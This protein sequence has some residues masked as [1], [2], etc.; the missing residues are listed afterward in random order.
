MKRF[1]KFNETVYTQY[2][3]IKKSYEESGGDYHGD[4]DEEKAADDDPETLEEKKADVE[5]A[6]DQ[7]F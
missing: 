1:T 7:F 2:E 6:C 5:L 3:E 4:S